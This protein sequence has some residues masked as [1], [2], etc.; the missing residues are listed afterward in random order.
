[1]LMM[2]VMMVMVMVIKIL[3]IIDAH[4]HISKIN[5]ELY[6]MKLI[7]DQSLLQPYEVL[8]RCHL[9]DHGGRTQPHA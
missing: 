5:I 9:G 8:R 6:L 3:A 1:M 2:V 7:F 4:D